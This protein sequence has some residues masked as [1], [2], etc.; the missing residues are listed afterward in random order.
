MVVFK[1][2]HYTIIVIFLNA[3]SMKNGTTNILKAIELKPVN[4]PYKLNTTFLNSLI[5]LN[6]PIKN[7]CMFQKTF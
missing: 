2:G 4:L 3:P 1:V 5:A 7:N 6:K